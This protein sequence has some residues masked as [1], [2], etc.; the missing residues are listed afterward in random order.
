MIKNNRTSERLPVGDSIIC[1]NKS[2]LI[3]LRSSNVYINFVF[4]DGTLPP[5][6]PS[7]L[8]HCYSYTYR[9][10]VRYLGERRTEDSE[11][12][13][14]LKSRFQSQFKIQIYISGESFVG[15]NVSFMFELA[16]IS[17]VESI[18]SISKTFKNFQK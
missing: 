17:N 13:A 2:N 6:S 18:A 16:R 1:N 7:V 14:H 4:E 5:F 8:L 15:S 11:G 3:Q 12:P 9:L 10:V